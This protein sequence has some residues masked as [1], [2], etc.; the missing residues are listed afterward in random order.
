MRKCNVKWR[1]HRH[2]HGLTSNLRYL[3][4]ASL[5]LAARRTS[6][7]VTEHDAIQPARLDCA[8]RR[9]G[10]WSSK[11]DNPRSQIPLDESLYIYA[12]TNK[13]LCKICVCRAV[14]E[15]QMNNARSSRDSRLLLGW[16]EP[17]T[18][19]RRD[20]DKAH[21]AYLG[22]PTLVFDTPEAQVPAACHRNGRSQQNVYER[23][24]VQVFIH[25]ETD[26]RRRIHT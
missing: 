21:L 25:I 2:S 18:D 10:C 6:P 20:N 26:I 17:S 12:R 7:L 8:A 23:M 3:R 15:P 4:A 5:I 1:W 16:P 9:S 22:N 24:S 14:A 13:I 11:S 19:V